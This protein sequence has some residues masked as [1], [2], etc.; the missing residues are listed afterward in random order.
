MNKQEFEKKI[1]AE[2]S[3]RNYSIIE[4]VYTW[5]PAID[6]IKGKDQIA[7]LY[8]GFGMTIIN[9][10]VEAASFMQDL[11]AEQR[12]AKAAL[13]EVNKRIAMVAKGNLIQERCNREM[14]MLF[15]MA[16]DQEQWDRFEEKLVQKYGSDAVE[17]AEH[18]HGI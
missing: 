16:E 10:M 15:D 11:D 12:K 7:D 8:L 1:G 9:G 13:E 3:D 4:Q 6:N 14:S 5:H 17:K 2:V 18:Y